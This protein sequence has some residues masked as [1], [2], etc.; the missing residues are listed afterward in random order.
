MTDAAAAKWKEKFEIQ[1]KLLAGF[2]V[3]VVFDVGAYVGGY[4]KAYRRLFPHAQIYAFEPLRES[5][6]TGVKRMKDDPGIRLLNLAVSD[7][8]GRIPLYRNQD[9]LTSST[10]PAAETG[11]YVDALTKTVECVEVESVTID[12]FCRQ[13]NIPSIDILKLDIQGAELA[14]LQGASSLLDSHKIRLLFVEVEFMEIYRGQPLFH[15]VA[16]F[17]TGKGYSLYDFRGLSYTEKGQLAWGDAIFC[18]PEVMEC[19]DAARGPGE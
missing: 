13:E 5:Y 4:A 16:A 7:R 12:D 14:A 17:L 3:K 15:D 6:E 1:K 8:T 19:L 18:S 2:E 10:I 11:T 9:V